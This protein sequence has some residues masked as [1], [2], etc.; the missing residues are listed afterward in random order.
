MENFETKNLSKQTA[1]AL[2]RGVN[3]YLERLW[4]TEKRTAAQTRR[5]KL[6]ARLLATGCI[7]CCV[8]ACAGSGHMGQY[9]QLSGTPEGIRALGDTLIGMNRTA[10][11]AP[12]QNSEYFAHRRTQEQHA[13]ERARIPGLFSGLFASKQQQ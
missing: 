1:K 11:E 8:T 13:T 7:V 5:L 9:A 12:E 2:L 3:M 10:K 4:K 6:L